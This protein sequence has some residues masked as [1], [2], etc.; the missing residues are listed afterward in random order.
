M[1]NFSLLISIWEK[2]DDTF[3]REVFPLIRESSEMNA[4]YPYEAN[5]TEKRKALQHNPL[6]RTRRCL[7]GDDRCRKM[8]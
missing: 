7:G 5:P 6:G 4:T 1:E 3:I 2:S 8:T